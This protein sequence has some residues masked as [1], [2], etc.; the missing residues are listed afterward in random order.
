MPIRSSRNLLG[1]DRKDVVGRRLPDLVPPDQS[2]LVSDCLRK[3]LA[4]EEAP[5][6]FEIDLIGMQGQLSRLE[7][8]QHDRRSRRRRAPC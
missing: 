3:C 2:E 7:T 4:G 5:A 1:V 6:R 8:Q